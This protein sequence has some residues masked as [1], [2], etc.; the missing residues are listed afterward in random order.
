[1]LR[2]TGETGAGVQAEEI[3]MAWGRSEIIDFSSRVFL[4]DGLAG[5]TRKGVTRR[6]PR[7]FGRAERRC[8]WAKQREFAFD[9]ASD[10]GGTRRNAGDL[11]GE[12]E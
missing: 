12:S 8:N 3:F 10:R 5:L 1:V 11:S 2:K 6:F 4:R 7:R 9:L